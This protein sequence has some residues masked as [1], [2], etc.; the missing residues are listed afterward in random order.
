M[1]LSYFIH[2]AYIISVFSIGITMFFETRKK[3]GNSKSLLSVVLI[4]IGIVLVHYLFGI[5]NNSY[6]SEA[7]IIF[8]IFV[9]Y[10]KKERIGNCI[11]I[12]SVYCLGIS[13]S[14]YFLIYL[15]SIMLLYLKNPRIKLENL[16]LKASISIFLMILFLVI[17]VRFFAKGKKIYSKTY[18]KKYTITIIILGLIIIFSDRFFNE[19][20]FENDIVYYA[21]LAAISISIELGF[22]YFSLYKKS[23][24]YKMRVQLEVLEKQLDYQ[25]KYYEQ[26]IT[27]YDDTRKTFHDIKNH[28]NVI[29]YLLKNKDY[30]SMEEYLNNLNNKII[31]SD[32]NICSNKIINAI[33][34]EKLNRCKEENINIEFDININKELNINALDVCI[35]FGNLIDNAIEACETNDSQKDIKV[36]VKTEFNQLSLKIINSKEKSLIRVGD[37]ILTSKEDKK[38]HGIGLENVKQSVAKN[39]GKIEFNDLKDFFEVTLY[40]MC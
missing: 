26:V 33:C 36:I 9:F 37:K 4:T 38:N 3:I 31:Y 8:I 35:I 17:I 21:S 12:T 34:L 6:L 11:L 22:V 5:E 20:D 19:I 7:V 39:N 40:V 1:N 13:L 10:M 28:V 29:S 32:I 24:E 23:K 14:K 2:T 30:D 15:Y 27:N 16:Y 18:I 25:K